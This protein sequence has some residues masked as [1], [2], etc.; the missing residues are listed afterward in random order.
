MFNADDT[1]KKQR[2][3][4]RTPRTGRPK[5]AVTIP[6]YT[7]HVRLTDALLERIHHERERV[8]TRGVADTIRAIL[9]EWARKDAVENAVRELARQRKLDREGGQY[10][11]PLTLDEARQRK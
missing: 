1:P 11:Q 2:R 3:P 9:E 8:G 5:L 10:P 7:A 6:H 4:A